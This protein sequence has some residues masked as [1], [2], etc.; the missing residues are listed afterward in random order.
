SYQIAGQYFGSYAQI[1]EQV[2]ALYNSGLSLKS[3][4][5]V[6]AL[7]RG[8]ALSIN[9]IKA[10]TTRYNDKA[11]SLVTANGQVIKNDGHLST[12]SESRGAK[13]SGGKGKAEGAHK[14]EQ[15]A[16]KGTS[17]EIKNIYNSI[18]D[19]PQY[20]QNFKAVQNGTTRNIVKNQSLLEQFREI[21]PGKWTKVYK[22]GFDAS[23]KKVSIHYFQS[24]SGKVF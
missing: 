12:A 2:D 3:V 6:I 22:D 15:V 18:K 5:N 17:D 16:G 14:T 21:E 19:S 7:K 13:Q 20:P 8:K 11:G 10:I 4:I 1:G 23:G 24:Q 9:E